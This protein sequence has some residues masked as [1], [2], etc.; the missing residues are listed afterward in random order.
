MISKQVVNICFVAVCRSLREPLL[1]FWFSGF[2]GGLVGGVL[3][4][5]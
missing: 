3:G 1:F 4:V 2:S 5:R